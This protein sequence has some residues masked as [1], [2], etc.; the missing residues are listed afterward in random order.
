MN[1]QCRK[2][3]YFEKKADK[4]QAGKIILGF[5]K[6]RQRYV[7][8]TTINEPVC[9]D[10]AVISVVDEERSNVRMPTF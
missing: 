1:L 10:R 9:K 3:P 8:D 4:L 2:C 7:A 6:L 5:C